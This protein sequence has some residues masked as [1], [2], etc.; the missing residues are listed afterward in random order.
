MN[1]GATVSTRPPFAKSAEPRAISRWAERDRALLAGAAIAVVAVAVRVAFAPQFDGLDDAGYLDAATR[2]ADGRSLDN[3]FPLFRTR[4]GMS[5]PLAWLMSTGV[6]GA[7]Q[8]WILTCLADLIATASL[9]VAAWLLTGAIE[10]GLGAAGVYAIYPLAVQQSAMYYPTSFQ[11]ASIALA[12]ALIAIAERHEGARRWSAAMGAGVSL[13]VGYLFKEDV[14]IVVAAMGLASLVARFPRFTTMI[15]V[16]SGAALVFGSECL[17]Y[18]RTTGHPLYRLVATSGLGAPIG[19]N[20]QIAEIWRWD[21]YLRTLWLL[22]VQVGII[23]WLAIPAAWFAWRRRAEQ[24]GLA[25]T[26][27]LLAIVMLYLQFGSGSLAS[28]SPLPKTPRYTALATSLVMIAV[29]SWLAMGR[30][31]RFRTSTI[32]A[33]IVATSIPCLLYLFVT[34]GERTRNTLAAWQSIATLDSAP[35]YT[36]YYSARV[37]RLIEPHRDIR[38]WYHA[39]FKTG[40]MRVMN[41]PTAGSLVLLD[42][43]AAKVYTSSYQLRLPP[44]VDHVPATAAVIFS[45]HAY[46][47][48]SFSRRALEMLEG[49]AMLLPDGN[50]IR[51]RVVHGVEDIIGGDDAVLYRIPPSM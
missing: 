47:P 14:A 51:A 5:S 27:T 7:A 3:L 10:A 32:L 13:G 36:D 8:F 15:A 9:F 50:A 35:I 46:P 11:V 43:Q 31:D 29:G 2:I 22:P 38:T 17:A 41:E 12:C 25:F 42:R 16:G 23:W 33:A 4:V 39:D 44:A 21:A 6:L 37:L 28:Y 40:E 20:L 45:R 34:S 49:M 19:D 1:P 24:R 48:A 18:W 30:R 26:V